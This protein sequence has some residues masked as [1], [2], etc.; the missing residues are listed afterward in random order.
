M[1]R[2]LIPIREI[3][4]EVEYVLGFE[5]PQD[6]DKAHHSGMPRTCSERKWHAGS[7]D[8]DDVLL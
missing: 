8:G 2:Y 1:G 7:R 6:G 4:I 5:V 3:R